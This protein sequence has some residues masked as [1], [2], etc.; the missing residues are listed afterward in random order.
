MNRPAF[1]V[2]LVLLVCL[3]SSLGQVLFKLSVN[4]I[5]AGVGPIRAVTSL[6]SE[7]AFWGGGLLVA[8]GAAA[9]LYTLTRADLTYATPFLA[10]SLIVTMIASALVLHEA[11]SV[12]RVVGTLVVMAGLFLV[13]LSH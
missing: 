11:Q 1:V 4:R 8:A 2:P 13:G 9:W 10:L 12:G 3:L 6:L 5:G 7:P